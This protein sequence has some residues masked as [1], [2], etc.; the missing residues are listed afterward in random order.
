MKPITKFLVWV[1]FGFNPKPY[2]WQGFFSRDQAELA[3]AEA[4]RQPFVR[5]AEIEVIH[6]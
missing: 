1:F 3:L 6:D 2:L 4:T 5:F